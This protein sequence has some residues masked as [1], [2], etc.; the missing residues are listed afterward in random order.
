MNLFKKI[1]LHLNKLNE[2]EEIRAIQNK[3]VHLFSLC[4]NVTWYGFLALKKEENKEIEKVN[5]KYNQD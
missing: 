1:T 5:Y 3:Y 4:E 2:E